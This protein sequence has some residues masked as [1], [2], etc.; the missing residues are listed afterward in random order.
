MNFIL[1]Q[2]A[3]GFWPPI[4]KQKVLAFISEDSRQDHKDIL[5]GNLALTL[6]AL[7][8]LSTVFAK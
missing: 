2:S 1:A 3:L 7:R 5:N 8:I 4:H 6:L